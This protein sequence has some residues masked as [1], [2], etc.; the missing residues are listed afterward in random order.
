[1]ADGWRDREGFGRPVEVSTNVYSVKG[2]DD[3]DH[4]RNCEFIWHNGLLPCNC[5]A[6]RGKHSWWWRCWMRWQTARISRHLSVEPQD[7]VPW[8][9]KGPDDEAWIQGI[10]FD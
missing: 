10:D 2:P 9:I 8:P 4:A 1:M 5:D 6:T 7:R 3:A